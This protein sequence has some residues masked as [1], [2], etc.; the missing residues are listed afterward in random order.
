V[1]LAELATA[2]AG[3]ISQSIFGVLARRAPGRI[4][5]TKRD[6]TAPEPVPFAGE[7][8]DRYR[9]VCAFVNGRD[10]ALRILDPFVT[11]GVARGERL[12]YFIDPD[13]RANLVRHLGGLGFDVPTLFRQGQLDLQPWR[14]SHLHDGHFDQDAVLVQLD[15]LLSGSRTPR[16]RIISDM[17]WAID[18]PGISD[19]LVEFEARANFVEAQFDHVVI[20]VYDTKRF[21]GDVMIDMLRTHPFVLIGG[22]FQANPFFVP[23]A[24]FLEELRSRDR[25]ASDA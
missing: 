17:G 15:E 3:P 16:M 22:A 4:G 20:C 25:R 13:E 10:E 19:L 7:M 9:H 5:M 23:P 24:E 14:K 12:V 11:D 8:L 21:G 2:C 6:P 1:L 18:Q